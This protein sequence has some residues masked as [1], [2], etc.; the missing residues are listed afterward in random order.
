MTYLI[1]KPDNFAKLKVL[2]E[3]AKFDVCGL[4]LSISLLKSPRKT[5]SRLSRLFA[6]NMPTRVILT[7]RFYPGLTNLS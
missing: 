4:P 5:C 7:L 3:T 6:E 2:G 1:E